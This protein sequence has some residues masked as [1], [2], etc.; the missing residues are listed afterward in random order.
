MQV[1]GTRAE[2]LRIEDSTGK[3]RWRLRGVSQ[4][5][6]EDGGAVVGTDLDVFRTTAVV[7]R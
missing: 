1:A 2:C 5:L 4:K 3:A 7:L 6:G